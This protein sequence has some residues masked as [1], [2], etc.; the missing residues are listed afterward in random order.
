M[1]GWTEKRNILGANPALGTARLAT[2]AAPLACYSATRCRVGLT[3]TSLCRLLQAGIA[4]FWFG[5]HTLL[6]D[7]QGRLCASTGRIWSCNPFLSHRTGLGPTA[8]E[9]AR[10]N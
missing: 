2:T 8:P 5:L 10:P 3:I 4:C 1:Y 6:A 7:D 9:N